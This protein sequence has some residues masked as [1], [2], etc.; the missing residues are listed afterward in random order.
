LIE[1]DGLGISSSKCVSVKTILFLMKMTFHLECLSYIDGNTI[2]FNLNS[3]LISFR[4]NEKEIW[5]W[6][7]I[8][9]IKFKDIGKLSKCGI[10]LNKQDHAVF[11]ICYN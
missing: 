3:N 5:K 6:F 11:S 1:L 10:L 7:G 2:S 9:I 4:K 8:E